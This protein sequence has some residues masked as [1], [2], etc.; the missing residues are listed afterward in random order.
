MIHISYSHH[1]LFEGL[2][3]LI[4]ELGSQFSQGCVTSIVFYAVIIDQKDVIFEVL[5]CLIAVE[6]QFG[7]YSGEIHGMLHV[8]EVVCVVIGVNR[9]VE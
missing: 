5:L 2:S 7:P 1:F 9:Y 8:V 4:L 6:L 3:K